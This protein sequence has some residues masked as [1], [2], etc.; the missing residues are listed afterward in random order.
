[1]IRTENGRQVSKNG[2]LISRS[3]YDVSGAHSAT[4]VEDVKSDWRHLVD[5]LKVLEGGRYLHHR[6]HPILSIW[7]LGA[8]SHGR[9]FSVDSAIA[10]LDYFASQ[11]VT[12]MGGVPTGW[13]DLTRDSE[14]DPRWYDVYR[15]FAVIS[16][17]TVGRYTSAD[18]QSPNS[19]DKFLREYILPDM[20]AAK[21]AGADYLPVVFPG[22]SAHYEPR[23]PQENLNHCPRCVYS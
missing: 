19:V 15:R 12:L 8:N 9:N 3:R 5:D 17:W 21:A 16:P 7:G 18:N 22:D 2:H 6:G 14:T 1:L 4:L 13:R 11:N 10:I 23:K 20:V